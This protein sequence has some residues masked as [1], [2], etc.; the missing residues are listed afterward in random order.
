MRPADRA[1]RS[2]ELQAAMSPARLWQSQHEDDSLAEKV[3]RVLKDQPP[4]EPPVLPKI[5][6]GPNTIWQ[7]SSSAYGLG[8]VARTDATLPK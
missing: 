4:E 7:D 8:T 5:F 3:D 2:F 1:P 6:V